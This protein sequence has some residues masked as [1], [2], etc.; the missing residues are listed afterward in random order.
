MNTR[1]LAAAVAAAL[2]IQTAP[3]AYADHVEL[4]SDKGPP[5]A[6][7]LFDTKNAKLKTLTYSRVKAGSKDVSAA[8]VRMIRFYASLGDNFEMGMVHA[9]SGAFR[10]AAMSFESAAAELKGVR[11]QHALYMRME[12]W[13][14]DGKDLKRLL[15]AADEL[16]A[17][18]PDTYYFFPAQELRA[19]LFLQQRKGAEAKA[20]LEAVTSAAGMNV[21]DFFEAKL[22][23]IRF[24]EV[25]KAGGN[26][27][28]NAV[29][30]KTYRDL[31]REIDGNTN[32]A[33]ANV[34]RMKA[35]VGVSQALIY[36]QKYAEA[37]KELEKVVNDNSITDQALLAAAYRGLG[38]AIYVQAKIAD[39]AAGSDQAKKQKVVVQL[40][41]AMLHYMRVILVYAPDGPGY[42]ELLPS[43]TSCA[44]VCANLFVMG[45]EKDEAMGRKAYGFFHQAYNMMGR[46]EAK[47]K[48]GAE[49]MQVKQALDALKGGSEEKKGGNN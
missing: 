24:F 19:R 16:L 4:M 49:A 48:L 13:R 40:E 34:Q 27:A 37:Q 45:G 10:E 23:S 21:R 44:R 9:N 35:V 32:K 20:A 7:K 2:M 28:K 39:K 5:N 8:K 17:E 29:I 25:P 31:V 1:L 42:D 38:D 43:L 3:A 26:A 18:F 46:G 47:R 6:Q 36:Q 30:E 22:A 15:Q 12:A 33:D 41:D 11:K 14:G